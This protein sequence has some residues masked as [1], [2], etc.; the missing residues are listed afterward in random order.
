ME[1][2]ATPN[3]ARPHTEPP[4]TRK[5]RVSPHSMRNRLARV[6]WGVVQG[7]IFRWSPPQLFKFRVWLLRLFG[8]DIAPKARIYPKAKIWGP[9]NLK[10]DDLATLANDVDCYCVEKITIGAMTTVSQY[11]YLCGASHDHE[12]PNFRLVPKPIT[13]GRRAWIAADVFVAPGV[14]IGDGSVV[15]ARSS[16]FTDMPEWSII[17]GT[18][19]K[20]VGP[21][22]LR[23][24]SETGAMGNGQ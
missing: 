1:E 4:D 17:V 13:I 3:A 8:G 9:W 19:A 14:T 6:L 20:V 15:G 11:S 24:P 16:V 22:V 23:D 5:K 12:D 2:Q 7:T 10:M 18:P 21:R